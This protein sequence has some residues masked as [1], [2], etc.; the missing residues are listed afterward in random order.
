MHLVYVFTFWLWVRTLFEEF[1]TSVGIQHCYCIPSVL[2]TF[3]WICNLPT[4]QH[5][6]R[7]MS[8]SVRSHLW[9][10]CSRWCKQPLNNFTQIIVI[11]MHALKRIT[12]YGLQT[13]I[14][15]Q[16]NSIR[17]CTCI[18]PSSTS[19]NYILCRDCELV[20]VTPSASNIVF[21]TTHSCFHGSRVYRNIKR[22]VATW[23]VS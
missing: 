13:G 7:R 9:V 3:K 12:L 21:I 5:I 8:F 20:I 10:E 23:G 2:S 18:H 1:S 17:K 14:K 15:L 22:G 11:F 4:L 19:S 6:R 16:S